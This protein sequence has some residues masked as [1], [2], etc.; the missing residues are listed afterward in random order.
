MLAV[1][2]FYSVASNNQLRN[3]VESN[4]H[5]NLL[6]QKKVDELLQLSMKSDVKLI[7]TK[8]QNLQQDLQRKKQILH[9]ISNKNLGN[10]K[11][12]SEFL[13]A[14]SKKSLITLSLE[15]FTLQNGG[16]YVELYGVAKTADQIP[17]YIQRLKQ[18]SVFKKSTFG[19]L[20]VN[21]SFDKSPV[22]V[23]S[24]S[25]SQKNNSDAY[26]TSVQKKVSLA[27]IA[28]GGKHE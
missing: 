7:D 3:D 22:Y 6:L 15:A 2:S 23:F 20:Q 16:S 19:V 5:K 18:E 13:I 24:L 1:V 28:E 14:M 12:F 8:I 26:V 17:L 27:K 9:I 4:T 10:N 25:Q 11:G 21:P